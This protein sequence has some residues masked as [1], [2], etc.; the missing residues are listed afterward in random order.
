MADSR[1]RRKFLQNSVMLGGAVAA[2]NGQASAASSPKAVRD[3]LPREVWVGTVSMAKMREESSE[4]M[5]RR[6]L[7]ALEEVA[8]FKP[9]IVCLSETFSVANVN[10]P[11]PLEERAPKWWSEVLG[12]FSEF[13]AKHDCYLVCPVH[14]E[15]DGKWYNSAVIIDREGNCQGRY[16]KIHTT[17]GEME[18]GLTAGPLDP[19]VFETDFGKIG[20]QICFDIE[21]RDGWTKLADKGAEIV[22]WPSAFGGGKMVNTMAWLHQYAVVSSTR[23]SPSKICDLDGTELATTSHWNEWACAAINLEKAFLHTWPF[24]R[25]FDEIQAKYGRKIRITNHADEEWS[26]LESRSPDVQVA[27]ILKEFELKTLREHLQEAELAQC[28]C[29]EA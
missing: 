27:D 21:W 17:T 3:R 18:R 13:A 2:F 14:T 23:K 4:A 28:D 22:F 12:P 7:N 26:V 5:S 10:A 24:V 1:V 20:A 9:D 15:E 6:L 19:P 8:A 25:H 16:H 11:R 29:R